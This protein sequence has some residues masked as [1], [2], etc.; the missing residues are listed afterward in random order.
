MKTAKFLAFSCVH[1]PDTSASGRAWLISKIEEHKPSHLIL[2]GDLLDAE[3]A[4]VHPG[5]CDH[6]L[7]D[8]YAFAHAF[9]QDCRDAAGSAHLVWTLGNHDD[10]I[11]RADPRRIPANLRSLVHWNQH[12]VFGDGFRAWKQYSY[13]KSPKAVYSLGQV[14]FFHGFDCGVNSDELEGLQMNYATGGHPWRL[15]VRG[16]THRPVGVCQAKRSQKVL[17]PHYYANAG[18]IVYGDKQPEYMYRKDVTQW[19][20][21]VVVGEVNLEKR[22]SRAT[23]P[24]WSATVEK[25]IPS[26]SSSGQTHASQRQTQK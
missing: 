1:A 3:A 10:N 15:S 9:L 24:E 18:A 11:L 5:E 20:A 16:H 4:S 6:D 14:M 23:A 2:L 13:I 8:E 19:G 7:N 25:L 22:V 21:A 12:R 26:P 17:L